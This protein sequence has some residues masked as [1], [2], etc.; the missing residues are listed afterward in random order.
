M[1][2]VQSVLPTA[3]GDTEISEFV[4]TSIYIDSNIGTTYSPAV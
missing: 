3:V 2:F 1:S 4:G